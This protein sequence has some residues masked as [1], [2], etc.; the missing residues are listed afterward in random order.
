MN[1]PAR[2]ISK[3]QAKEVPQVV[4]A[5]LEDLF[6]IPEAE[7]RHE[8]IEGT[9]Y[10]KG[11]ASGEHGATQCGLAGWLT[12]FRRRPRAQG[13]GG[14]WIVTEVDVYFDAKNTF[15]PDVC[16]W[17]RERL[18]E[19]PKGT[20]IRVI[21]DWI[22]EILST[23]RGHD[24]IKKKRVYHR[25]QVGHY[26]IID[27]VEQLLEVLRWTPDGYLSVLAAECGEVV[28]AEPFEIMPFSLAS[29]FG[30]EPDEE[31]A[32]AAEPT[33]ESSEKTE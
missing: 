22:C 15:R 3:E 21:P 12:P 5:T 24:L 7:R 33:E 27:P 10:P 14:W 6:A 18:P 17:R 20:P 2:K 31:S 9:I 16:G 28:N 13:P 11:A 4:P 26:W 29:I 25:H 8:L 1:L 23:N 32:E 19:G 30:D